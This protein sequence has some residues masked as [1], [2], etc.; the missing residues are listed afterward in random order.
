RRVSIQVP[1]VTDG[2]RP[3]AYDAKDNCGT[4]RSDLALWL[5]DLR[6]NRRRRTK[7]LNRYTAVAVSRKNIG[8]IG[9]QLAIVMCSGAQAGVIDSHSAENEIPVED[10]RGL[11]SGRAIGDG[12]D[13]RAVQV[14]SDL[15]TGRAHDV[16]N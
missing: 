12:E 2:L 6:C 7:R 10:Y 3:N 13:S 9:V 5:R 14:I 4:R 16:A 8:I 15:E 1:V 11:R